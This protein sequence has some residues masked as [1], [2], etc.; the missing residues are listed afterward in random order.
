[1]IDV[2]RVDAPAMAARTV[3]VVRDWIDGGRTPAEVAVLARV[4]SALLPVQVALGEAGI[5]HTAALGPDV[6]RRTGIRTALAYLR[7]GLDPERMRRE[8]L[9]ET[10]RRPSRKVI[11]R[12][13][14][15]LRRSPRW[16][17]DRLSDVLEVLDGRAV[18]RLGEYLAD[19]RYLTGAITDGADTAEALSI[20]RNRIG[21][22]E[23]MDALD[24][25]SSR[26][27]GSS[28]GDDL[29]A[30]EQ[31]AALHPDPV[32]FG[33]WL[34]SRLRDPGDEQGVTL[35]TVHR[36]KGME[37]D[38]VVVFAAN[39]GLM[40]HRL[41]E[42]LE[43]ER[44]VFH[45]AITRCREACAVVAN[46]AASSPFLDELARPAAAR[47]TAATSPGA[48]PPRPPSRRD[49]GR[50]IAEPGV[51]VTV[52]GGFAGTVRRVAGREVTVTT[53]DG[54][55]L[56][57]RLGE[58]VVV[59]G[60]ATTLA[61]APPARPAVAP[62]GADGRA[63][64]ASAGTLAGTADAPTGPEVDPATVAAAGEALRAWRGRTAAAQGM[65]AYIILH[66][67]HLDAIASAQPRSL[68]ELARCP[69]IGPTKLDRYGDDI[70]AV[71]EDAG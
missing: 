65:P 51:Q 35:S 21:L 66:D 20:I 43:E 3:E 17:L 28:H 2:H 1:M 13:E 62:R 30:L 22:G 46:A 25:S 6:L 42:D 70:L 45:V 7:I 15:L 55:D 47:A 49:D 19:V 52:T 24:S 68:R 36:V 59:D 67:A 41:S 11:S 23:A 38:R 48:P 27:E 14:P 61:A 39:A 9:T 64:A 40:P 18:D 12:V 34:T 8:D 33:E 31:L 60:E 57:V 58:P 26:P 16:S 53:P 50:V 4:N 56:H 32:T 37:W 44:R 63:R 71:L 69:G 29:D 5:A 10:L 54:I